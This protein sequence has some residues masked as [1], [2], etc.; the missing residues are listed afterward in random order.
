MIVVNL[1]TSI[2]CFLV[3]DDFFGLEADD[4]RIVVLI[5]EIQ[6][7]IMSKQCVM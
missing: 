1:K 5:K 4:P 7:I 6:E 3:A 2:R